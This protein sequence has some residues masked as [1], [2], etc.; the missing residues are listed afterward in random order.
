MFLAHE[1]DLE[2]RMEKNLE[3]KIMAYFMELFI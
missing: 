3:G 1:D 2:K